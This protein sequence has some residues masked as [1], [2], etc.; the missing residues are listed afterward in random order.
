MAARHQFLGSSLGEYGR[1]ILHCTKC[2]YE[3]SMTGAV[4][5]K[6]FGRGA[7]PHGIRM[8]SRCSVCDKTDH[9]A[10]AIR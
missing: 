7:T 8:R 10:V 1:L 6:R 5:I 3:V 2:D 4:A 9:I